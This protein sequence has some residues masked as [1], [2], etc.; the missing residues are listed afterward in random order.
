MNL[1][2]DIKHKAMELGF[3]LVGITD[4]S[5]ID[6][7]HIGRLK[8]WL[9]SGCAGQMSYLNRNFEKRTHPA[10]LMGNARSV[11]C[12]ALNYKPPKQKQD[13]TTTPAGKVVSYAHYEDYHTFIKER[14]R[15]L[16]EFIRSVSRQ[17][18]EFKI[19]VDSVPLAERALAARAGLGFIGKNH[20][21][22]NPKLGPQIF[23]AE[24]ITTLKLPTDKPI[25][26]NCSDCD[27]CIVACPTQ[28]LTPDGNFDANKCINY[29]TIEYQGRIPSELSEKIGDRIFGCEQCVL[30][31]PYQKNTPAC[32]NKQFR[33]YT[34]RAEL[35][36]NW[37]LNL[38]QQEFDSVFADSAIKRSGIDRLKRNAR[39]CLENINS[40]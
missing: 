19:C 33:F 29:L 28:A 8:R 37:V 32:K 18:H 10:K 23:L 26:D 22:I 35:N 6:T 13:D 40:I 17:E 30:V 16:T 2:A 4:A 1:S 25:T 14:L 5:P 38:T 34:N 39:I 31:C 15:K 21:L 36:L 3:D 12:V 11:I 20:M 7:E 27:K 24:I 9:K